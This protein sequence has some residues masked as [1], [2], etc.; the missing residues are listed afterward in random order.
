MGSVEE[1][2]VVLLLGLTDFLDMVIC[3]KKVSLSKSCKINSDC[4]VVC[5]K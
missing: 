4:L 2:Q 3:V 5:V 1:E